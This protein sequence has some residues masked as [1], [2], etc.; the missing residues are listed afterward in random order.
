MRVPIS[1]QLLRDRKFVALAEAFVRKQ[2]VT[3]PALAA[4]L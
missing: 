3:V 1:K 2:M 4:E